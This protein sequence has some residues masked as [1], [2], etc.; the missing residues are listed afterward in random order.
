VSKSIHVRVSDCRAILRLVG[1]CRELGDD[2]D[3]WRH[4]FVEQLAGLVDAD[5]GDCG[6]SGGQ[7]ATGQRSLGVTHWGSGNCGD[8][9]AFGELNAMIARDPALYELLFRY[10][11]RLAGDDGVCH[12]RREIILD[13]EW[14]PSASYQ[15]VHRTLGVD[16][17]LWCFRSIGR[18]AVDEFSGA[19]LYRAIGR[20]DFS[21]RDRLV[22]REAHAAVAPLI[23][24]ALARFNEP[25]PSDLAR[26]ARQVLGCLLEGDGDKQIA[27]RLRLSRFT[28]NQYTKLI[29]R[30]FGVNTRP[31]LLARWIRRGWGSRFSWM[32]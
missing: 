20:R 14:Y 27:S 30:H 11:E 7:G 21:G 23:G 25:S 18:G 24:G 26:R 8:L 1:E 28:V 6:E 32:P 17:V 13:R 31:E 16:H 22:V 19:M 12:S 29:F 2:R 4:H 3:A 15:V 9:A 10:F 5:M